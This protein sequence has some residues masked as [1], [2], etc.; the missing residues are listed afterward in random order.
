LDGDVTVITKRAEE[1]KDHDDAIT[2]NVHVFLP[3]TMDILHKQHEII[4][5]SVYSDPGRTEPEALWQTLVALRTKSRSLMVF[6][7]ML[8]YRMSADI[9]AHLARMDVD[10]AL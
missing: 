4:K 1:F 6:A 5:R 2:R 9:Y 3:L 7:G 8:K 10:I